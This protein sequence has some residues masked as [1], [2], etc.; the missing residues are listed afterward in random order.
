MYKHID[1]YVNQFSVDLGDE[2]RRAV[3]TLFDKASALSLVPQASEPLFL[4]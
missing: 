1:L 2:G 3:R 4:E